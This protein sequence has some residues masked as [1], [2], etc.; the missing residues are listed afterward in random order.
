M[1][2]KYPHPDYAQLL[3]STTPNLWNGGWNGEAAVKCYLELLAPALGIKSLKENL[4]ATKGAN[5]SRADYIAQHERP[6][7]RITEVKKDLRLFLNTIGPNGSDRFAGLREDDES[8][9]PCVLSW[10]SLV[11][12]GTDKHGDREELEERYEGEV[13]VIDEDIPDKFPTF[14][15]YQQTLARSFE[16]NKF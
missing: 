13:I 9:D 7:P 10:P 5:T 14:T 8:Y 1:S 16:S 6:K 11:V 4:D 3:P 2:D 15:Q 12:A